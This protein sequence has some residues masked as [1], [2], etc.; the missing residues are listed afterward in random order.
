[1]ATVM[2]GERETNGFGFGH[3]PEL[4]PL[5][6]VLGDGKAV[7]SSGFDFFRRFF[8]AAFIS[9]CLWMLGD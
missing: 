2:F 7:S 3:Q 9:G 1:M 5:V 4:P 6:C 8:H